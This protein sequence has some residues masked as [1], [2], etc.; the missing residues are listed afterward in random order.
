[1]AKEGAKILI[2]KETEEAGKVAVKNGEAEKE[3]LLEEEKKVLEE[4]VEKFYQRPLQWFEQPSKRGVSLWFS[5]FLAIIFGLAAGFSA[6]LF[7]LNQ[8]KINLPFLKEINLI[9]NFPTREITLVTEKKITVIEEQRIAEAFKSVQPEVVRIYL[10]HTKQSPKLTS[11]LES[12]Y[13]DSEILGLGLVL[14]TDGWL[15][16]TSS[17]VSEPTEDYVVVTF[18]N[19]IFPVEKLVYD[20]FTNFVFLKTD[21]V[22]F[23]VAKIAERESLNLGQK[24]F[25]FDK[26]LGLAQ[27]TLA[28]L[29]V[30]PE[31]E[32][33]APLSFSTERLPFFFSFQERQGLSYLGAPV[34]ALDKSV[35]GLINSQGC[36]TP[37]F[38]LKNILPQILESGRISRPFLGLEYLD[39]QD[40]IGLK[41]SRYEGFNFGAIVY[42]EPESKTPAAKA[43]LKNGD[44]IIKVDGLPFSGRADL[45][46]L[47][48]TKKPGER[49]E[50]TIIRGGKELIL[51]T[52]LF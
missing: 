6:S 20:S 44:L 38:Y 42:G 32:K 28:N 2:K 14:T 18:E 43:G 49:I 41:D 26:N 11:L 39:L 1:M 10:A 31:I 4:K 3:K 19:K 29:F 23:P 34:F 21:L 15:L 7:V 37:V 50:F 30:R 52:V 12:I 45:T 5:I 47:V 25:F 40:L 9:K 22:N 13:Q 51:N 24:L 35:I 36:L 16:T 48:Q 17:V 46:S 8:G 33:K 27:G